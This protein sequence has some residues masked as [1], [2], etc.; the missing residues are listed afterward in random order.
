[1]KPVN[2]PP[3]YWYEALDLPGAWDMIHVRRLM[4]SR[5]MLHRY[6][7]QSMIFGSAGGT[8]D[9]VAATQGDGYAFIYLPSNYEV[10]IEFTY[11]K[12]EAFKT[13]W[14]NPRTGEASFIKEIT[15][16]PRETFRVPVSGVD[17]VLVID[18]ASRNFPK[19]GQLQ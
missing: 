12:G 8:I 2:Y 17:W 9:H 16:S 6:P 15:G 19:P 7:D 5:P 4:E 1:V 10:I 13:W 11:I 18:D 3:M 14:Y